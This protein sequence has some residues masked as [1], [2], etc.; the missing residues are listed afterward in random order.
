MA[1]SIAVAGKGGVG[2]TSVSALMIR[3]LLRRGKKPVL[4]VDADA[5]VNLNEALGVEVDGSVGSIREAMLDEIKT[6]PPGMS[7]EA[8]VQLKIE[9]SLVESEGF[10][11]LVMGRPE[12]PGCYC[13]ANNILRRYVDALS[14]SYP[15]I[16]IDNEAG[17]EHLSRRTTQ[18]IDLVLIVSDATPVGL[19]TAERI[20]RL[21]R[22]LKLDI[23]ESALVLNRV[24]GIPR[25]KIDE[26]VEGLGIELGAVLPLDQNLIEY[27]YSGKSLL[28]LTSDS[29][30]TKAVADLVD[31]YI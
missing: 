9:E 15:F 1:F 10:D 20:W 14:K 4:A 27:S 31:R 8:F 19:K 7:K 5:N 30:A 3:E 16:V 23:K 13:Y 28:N 29:L 11:L 17:M 6:L 21:A 22:D 25:E 24:N 12:G 26:M 18:N 2:K